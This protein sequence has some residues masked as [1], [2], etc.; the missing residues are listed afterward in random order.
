MNINSFFKT[1]LQIFSFVICYFGLF[2]LTKIFLFDNINVYFNNYLGNIYLKVKI[3][4]SYKNIIIFKKSIIDFN[5]LFEKYYNF[6]LPDSLNF[7][8]TFFCIYFFIYNLFIIYREKI[9]F[10][11]KIFKVI[12]II[13]TRL[14]NLKPNKIA[15]N[16]VRIYLNDKLTSK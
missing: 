16:R 5:N 11:T 9:F 10:I 8:N 3:S 14:I 12:F 7:F 6:I 13:I 4:N 2:F 1:Y 15:Y